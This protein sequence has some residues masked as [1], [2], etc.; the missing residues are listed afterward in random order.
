M[1]ALATV[2]EWLTQE[3]IVKT[4]I[5]KLRA[6]FAKQMGSMSNMA[7]DLVNNML[8]GMT[9]HEAATKAGYSNKTTGGRGRRSKKVVHAMALG[10]EIAARGAETTP[11]YI[12]QELK[13][14]LEKAKDD[15]DRTTFIACIKELCRIDGTYAEQ[16]L[17]L[18]HA[19][20]DGD[21]LQKDVTDKEFELLSHLYHQ[22]RE[23]EEQIT[24]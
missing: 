5:D 18:M 8:D 12:R 23:D 19:G 22:M 4:D 9:D 14:M 7:R 24:H 15:D 10:R 3:E 20:H 21:A 1:P 16:Q 11:V 13:A 2:C 6:V 17:K